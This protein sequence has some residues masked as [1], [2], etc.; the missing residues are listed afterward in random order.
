MQITLTDEEAQV[1]TSAVKGRIDSLLMSIA[2]ADTRS[3]RDGLIKEGA[4]LEAIYAQL[5]CSHEEWSEA[6]GCDFRPST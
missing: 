4:L 5:G 6:K 3:F 2:K 1:L